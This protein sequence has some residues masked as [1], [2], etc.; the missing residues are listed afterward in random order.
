MPCAV[1][2]HV[3]NE[4]GAR[5]Q[6]KVGTARRTGTAKED[7]PEGVVVL[8]APSRAATGQ[9]APAASTTLAMNGTAAA[10]ALPQATSVVAIVEGM[11][12]NMRCK[13]PLGYFRPGARGGESGGAQA[14]T[15]GAAGAGA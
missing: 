14:G 3:S 15:N 6:S 9:D 12:P 5:P 8:N 1:H 2:S 13:R 4:L 11:Q 7:V 10:E